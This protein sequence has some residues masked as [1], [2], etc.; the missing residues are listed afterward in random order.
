MQKERTPP[1]PSSDLLGPPLCMS[2]TETLTQRRLY[3]ACQDKQSCSFEA[4]VSGRPE[5]NGSKETGLL[6]VIK[7]PEFQRI[8]SL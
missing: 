6:E 3:L 1:S 7:I 5:G 2:D 8:W 4:L